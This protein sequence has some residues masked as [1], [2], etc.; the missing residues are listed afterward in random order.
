MLGHIKD[1]LGFNHKHQQYVSVILSLVFGLL[2]QQIIQSL[3]LGS[4]CLSKLLSLMLN[5]LAYNG[6]V[7][8]TYK[9][10]L[11]LW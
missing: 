3:G 11:S 1:T 4:T 7:D 2:F 6:L 9:T 10:V 5:V 8:K